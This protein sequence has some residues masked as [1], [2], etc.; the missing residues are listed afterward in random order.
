MMI[1]ELQAA[2]DP[3]AAVVAVSGSLDTSV[4][5]M[6]PMQQSSLVDQQ[7]VELEKDE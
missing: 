4:D 3:A 6:L 1:T 2:V 5:N 7:R